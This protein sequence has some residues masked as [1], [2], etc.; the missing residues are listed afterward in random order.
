MGLPRTLIMALC[1]KMMACRQIYIVNH[2]HENHGLNLTT[3]YNYKRVARPKDIEL[4]LH[5][6]KRFFKKETMN[7]VK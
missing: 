2:N 3:V 5:V 7:N 1:L 4:N 6:R